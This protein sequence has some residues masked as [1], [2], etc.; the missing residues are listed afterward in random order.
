MNAST[1]ST[2]TA[3]HASYA[4]TAV[5]IADTTAV[6]TT[7]ANIAGMKAVYVLTLQLFSSVAFYER[8]MSDVR[9]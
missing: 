1:G 8:V 4:T 6:Y 5:H 3:V 9:A 2:S 7:A